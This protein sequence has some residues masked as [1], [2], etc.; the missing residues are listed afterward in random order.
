MM[1]FR[2]ARNI[3]LLQ[4]VRAK[5]MLCEEAGEVLEIHILTAFLPEV[6]HAILIGNHEQLRPQINNY[7]LQY[8][9]PWG[10]RY[11]L[12][13]SLFEHLVKPQMG[14]L[15]IPLS[16]LK[17]QW[18]IHPS[19][20]ELV[21]VPLYSDL[22]DHP[23][24]S[25]YLRVDGMQDRLYWLNHQEKEDLQTVQAISLF[26]INTF[27]VDMIAAL[28]SHLVRQGT[29]ESEDI[30]VITL[31][32]GQL[33]KIRKRLANFFE[34]VVEDWDQEELKAK[35]LQDNL[36]ISADGQV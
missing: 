24:V 8:D 6:E 33:Q 32:L 30:A 3:K 9:N 36:E 29:Y 13:I 17:T 18:R 31:Y 28:I 25:E 16:T 34:I 19:I 23:S 11:S 12:N 1:M 2:L 10:K 26:R 7:E 15:W 14:N 5:V 4:H 35:G 20:S 21:R 22:Q 27:K